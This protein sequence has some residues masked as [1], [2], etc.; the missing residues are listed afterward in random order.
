MRGKQSGA[1]RAGGRRGR[2]LAEGRC[3]GTLARRGDGLGR[4]LC[5]LG[6][7]HGCKDSGAMESPSGHA[8]TV[9]GSAGQRGLDIHTYAIFS[10]LHLF[11]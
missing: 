2:A 4:G 7:L 3:N 11:T 6:E 9:S 1:L 8:R 10:R 5:S